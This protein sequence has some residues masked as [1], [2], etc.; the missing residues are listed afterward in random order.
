MLLRIL[1]AR[2]SLIVFGLFY[3]GL[4]VLL[5]NPQL[6][7]SL[8]TTVEGILKTMGDTS[9]LISW[10][11]FSGTLLASGAAVASAFA[12][13]KAS[14]MAKSSRDIAKSALRFQYLDSIK[15]SVELVVATLISEKTINVNPTDKIT[16]S[17]KNYKLSLKRT[18]WIFAAQ[19]VKNIIEQIITIAI[20]DT[21]EKL[22]MER[23]G[24][25]LEMKLSVVN[26]GKGGTLFTSDKPNSSYMYTKM[27]QTQ[28]KIRDEDMFVV[29][30]FTEEYSSYIAGSG[31]YPTKNIC[32]YFSE[33]TELSLS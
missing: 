21:D 2:V 33:L 28:E 3:I 26:A 8:F 5:H 31:Q 4:S 9:N 16:V 12:T 32:N 20:D 1:K 17:Q 19:E 25:M 11:S 22:L 13:K 14:D 7:S 10:L 23:Y 29:Y 18:D 15:E 24:R 27:I 6:T 30:L